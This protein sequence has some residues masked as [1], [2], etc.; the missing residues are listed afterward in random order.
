MSSHTYQNPIAID[1]Q[2]GMPAIIWWQDLPSPAQ[3]G[4]VVDELDFPARQQP[5]QQQLFTNLLVA[6]QHELCNLIH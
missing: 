6:E 4:V 1:L 2:S 3:S 5:Y